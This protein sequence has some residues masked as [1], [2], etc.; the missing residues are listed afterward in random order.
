MNSLANSLV[1]PEAISKFR[2]SVIRRAIRFR[3]DT[4]HNLSRMGPK[5]LLKIATEY[6]GKVYRNSTKGLTEAAEDLEAHLETM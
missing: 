5:A 3:I 4:G 6:T 1:T 2:V